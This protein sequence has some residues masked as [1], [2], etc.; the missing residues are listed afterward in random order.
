M[1]TSRELVGTI[2]SADILQK[3][4]KD[5]NLGIFQKLNQKTRNI[6]EKDGRNH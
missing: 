1:E 6:R 2:F 3:S 5:A 4:G